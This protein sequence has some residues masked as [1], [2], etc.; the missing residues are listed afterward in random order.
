VTLAANQ[1]Y[2]I[3]IE[4][5][6]NGGGAVAKLEWQSARQTREIVPA[7]QLY[8]VTAPTIP[9]PIPTPTPSG[10][11]TGLLGSYF[12]NTSLSGT[13]VSR[14]DAQ[15]DFDWG[16]GTAGLTGPGADDFSVRW[17]GMLEA[18]VSG[19]YTFTTRSDDGVRL[20]VNGTQIIDNWN[21]HAPTNDV[22]TQ[23]ITLTAGQKVPIKMEYYERGGGAEARLYW[24]YPGQNTDIIP[25]SYLYSN[26]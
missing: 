5:Y 12:A 8:P 24:A 15:V 16:G 10:S 23:T 11:G 21:D 6:E 17:E 18:P 3:R 2:D 1:K 4:Y 14:L 22:G 7:S 13:A 19:T 25:K 26:P 9:T 20:W